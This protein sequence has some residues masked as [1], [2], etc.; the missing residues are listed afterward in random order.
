MATTEIR[1]MKLNVGQAVA[2]DFDGVIH[3]YS[4][5]WKDGSIYDEYNEQVIEL[6]KLLQRMNIPVFILSTR[7]VNQIK[8]W[9]DE[10]EFDIPCQLISNGEFFWKDTAVVGITNRKLPAQ[11]YIDDR[12]YRYEGQG[13]KD[14][15]KD[16]A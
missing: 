16:F 3:K 4:E 13:V 5:G 9:W 12:A 6:I 11:L 10:Q 7:N 14:F 15:L 8:K 2:F 1:K